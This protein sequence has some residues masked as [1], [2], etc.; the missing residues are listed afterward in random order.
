MFIS[1][2][3]TAGNYTVPGSVPGPEGSERNM[4]LVK[5]GVGLKRLKREVPCCRVPGMIL[6]PLC[7]LPH[8]FHMAV[9]QVDS[10]SFYR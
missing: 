5:K 10:A 4:G 1:L 3:S 7:A 2:K 9:S 8:L 6:R